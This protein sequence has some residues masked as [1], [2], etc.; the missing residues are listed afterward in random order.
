M[1]AQATN[2]VCE[3]QVEIPNEIAF[4]FEGYPS[5]KLDAVGVNAALTYTLTIRPTTEIIQVL[6]FNE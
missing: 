1:Q 5:V 2:K 6:D 4:N 3:W